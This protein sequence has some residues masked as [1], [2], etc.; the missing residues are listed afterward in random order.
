MCQLKYLRKLPNTMGTVRVDLLLELYT[1]K[2]A[3]Y[4]HQ[5]TFTWIQSNNWGIFEMNSNKSAQVLQ[6]CSSFKLSK[7]MWKIVSTC[8]LETSSYQSSVLEVNIIIGRSVLQQKLLVFQV[9]QA[10]E[11]GNNQSM[12]FKIK[13]ILKKI[14]FSLLSSSSRFVGELFGWS[15][16][17]TKI[18]A[19]CV[20]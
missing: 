14:L 3:Y 9:I 18:V 12:L 15:L 10:W 6:G 1:C 16:S 20:M 11:I 17:S 13:Q 5:T 8:S 2:Y 7:S 4:S 19:Q